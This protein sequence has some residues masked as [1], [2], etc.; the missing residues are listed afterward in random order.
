MEDEPSDFHVHA[1]AYPGGA[2]GAQAPPPLKAQ[3][4]NY[5]VPKQQK[6]LTDARDNFS[7]PCTL[8]S[9]HAVGNKERPP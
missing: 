2:Q 4:C 1:V 3:E 5:I 8:I 9:Q 6:L 7:R